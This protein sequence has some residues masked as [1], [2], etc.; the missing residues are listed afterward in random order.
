[1]D[2]FGNGTICE[3]CGNECQDNCIRC[4]ATQCCDYC[5]L[6]ATREIIEYYDSLNLQPQGPL[7]DM[8]EP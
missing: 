8:H 2:S 6:Q 3:V 5:C 1:M 7:D 4:G